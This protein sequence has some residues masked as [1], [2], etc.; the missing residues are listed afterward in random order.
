[1]KDKLPKIVNIPASMEKYYGVGTMLHPNLDLVIP[2][3]KMIT[4]G[5]LTTIDL[6]GKQLAKEFSTDVTCPMRL[7]NTIKKMAIDNPEAHSSEFP[8]W[9]VIRTDGFLV[10]TLNVTDCISLLNEEGFETVIKKSGHVK[11]NYKD[12]QVYK[13]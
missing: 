6:I 1:M 8:Y 12:N 10:K 4:K 13:Y 9:R 11:V 5:Y 2:L 3:V 7:G